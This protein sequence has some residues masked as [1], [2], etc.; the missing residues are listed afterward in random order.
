MK[1]QQSIEA[2]ILERREVATAAV[3]TI[4][5]EWPGSV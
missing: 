4:D 2:A 3:R 1:V 5:R